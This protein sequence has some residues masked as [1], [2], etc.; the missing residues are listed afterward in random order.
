MIQPEKEYY[1]DGQ[2]KLEGIFQENGKKGMAKK[3]RENGTLEYIQRFDKRGVEQAYIEYA[4]DGKVLTETFYEDGKKKFQ[5][6]KNRVCEEN[7]S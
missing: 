6:P 3:Y 5:T 4:K 1:P 2:L 7:I